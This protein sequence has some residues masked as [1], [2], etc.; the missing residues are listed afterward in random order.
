MKKILIKFKKEL[1]LM[2]CSI[3]IVLGLSTYFMHYQMTQS[4]IT[5]HTNK[6]T[7]LKNA[8]KIYIEDYF[9]KTGDILLTLSDSQTVITAI[10]QFTTA[11]HEDE[12]YATSI[13]KID[14]Q[15]ITATLRN[16]LDRVSYEV[17]FAN[18]QLPE[19][20]YPQYCMNKG[21]NSFIIFYNS[22]IY[23]V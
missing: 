6:L 8:L 12:T 19:E 3:L 14:H 1:S 16:Y 9:E 15:K 20:R 4:M 22:V 7:S 2:M 21:G 17:P 10:K 5:E 18:P 23:P 13:E 11:F